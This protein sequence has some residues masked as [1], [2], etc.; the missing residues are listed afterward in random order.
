MG[1]YELRIT[2]YELRITNYE[3]RITDGF[4]V[5]GFGGKDFT[6]KKY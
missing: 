4:W 2:N 1:N 5:L 6:A 3:L